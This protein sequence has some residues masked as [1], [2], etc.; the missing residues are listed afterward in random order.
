MS[1]P[2]G[3]LFR[4]VDSIYSAVQEIFPLITALG[5]GCLLQV[6]L[7]ALQAA[8]PLKDMATASS[9]FMFLR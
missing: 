1:C 8:M 6:P 7:V 4:C 2:I 9:G 5:F 3:T